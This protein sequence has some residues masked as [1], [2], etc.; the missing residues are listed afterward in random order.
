MCVLSV[1]VP[2]LMSCP[3]SPKLLNIARV[4]CIL[5]EVQTHECLGSSNLTA[6]KHLFVAILLPLVNDIL[7]MNVILLFM[8][9][10]VIPCIVHLCKMSSCLFYIFTV[11]YFY[12]RYS[13]ISFEG[14]G[15]WIMSIYVFLYL[16]TVFLFI[17]C[18]F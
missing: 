15:S 10:P 18:C 9:W 16:N 12:V 6:L 4:L 5:G 11:L 8:Q 1:V 17:L 3:Y 14:G 7:F 13:F 2:F